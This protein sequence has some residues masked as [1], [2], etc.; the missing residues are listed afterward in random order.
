MTMN[1]KKK[2]KMMIAITV[3]FGF[4]FITSA[5]V[6]GGQPSAQAPR[7]NWTDARTV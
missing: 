4:E 1:K 2:K 5:V 7:Q 3:G 6:T